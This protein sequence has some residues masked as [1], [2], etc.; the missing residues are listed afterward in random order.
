VAGLRSLLLAERFGGWKPFGPNSG[1]Y[2]G[3]NQHL[4]LPPK[5]LP[6]DERQLTTVADQVGH[7]AVL[8]SS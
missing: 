1:W 8:I 4:S 7:G 5:A 2:T 6:R 3:N